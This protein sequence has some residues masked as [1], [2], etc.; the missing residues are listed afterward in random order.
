MSDFLVVLLKIASMFRSCAG[1]G[2]RK[3]ALSPTRPAGS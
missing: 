2:A 3:R 1:M